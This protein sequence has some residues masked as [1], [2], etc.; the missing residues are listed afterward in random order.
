ME[1]DTASGS[2]P[3]NAAIRA[4]HVLRI[5]GVGETYGGLWRV[6]S[7]RQ[8]LDGSGWRTSFEARKEIWLKEILSAAIPVPPQGE[9]R[10]QGGTL[11]LPLGGSAGS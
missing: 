4:G 7:V 3:G 10:V 2:C 6:T 11:S 5:E 8:S 9:V 1:P